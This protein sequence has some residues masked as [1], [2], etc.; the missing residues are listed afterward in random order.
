[1]HK[2][3]KGS[4][5]LLFLSKLLGLLKVS[6]HDGKKEVHQDNCSHDNEHDKVDSC[7]DT[8]APYMGEHYTTPASTH[9]HLEDGK[10]GAAK[11]VKVLSRRFSILQVN[12]VVSIEFHFP[13]IEAHSNEWENVDTKSEEYEIGPNGLDGE[14][15]GI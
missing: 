4:K 6:Q 13:S 10:D 5:D 14:Y 8:R 15:D 3:I 7:A 12:I 11:S 2:L 1:M 9:E